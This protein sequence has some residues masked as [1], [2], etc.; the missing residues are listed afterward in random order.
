LKHLDEISGDSERTNGRSISEVDVRLTEVSLA[1]IALILLA[2][3]RKL[4]LIPLLTAIATVAGTFLISPIYTSTASFLPPQ[5]QGVGGMLGAQLGALAGLAGASMGIKNPADQYV[6]LLQSR[7]VTDRMIVRFDLRKRYDTEYIEQTRKI[8]DRR[9]NVSAGPKDGLVYIEVEDEDKERAAEMANAFIEELKNVMKALA[10][11]EAAQRRLFFEEQMGASRKALEVAEA[12][13]QASG[14]GEALLRA[15]PRAAM[16]EVARL[17][18]AVT[19]AELKLSSLL[20]FLSEQNPDVI[21]AK[22]EVRDLRAKLEQ[23]S[24]PRTGGTADSNAYVSK[25][26]DFKYQEFLFEQLARQFEL[27]RIDEAREGGVIQV[28]DRAVAAER[29]T[30][31]KRL[32][33]GVIAGVLTLLALLVYIAMQRVF[34]SLARDPRMAT[35]VN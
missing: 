7:T 15:E 21:Q 13:L 26:R 34:Q 23:S 10:L 4:V 11:G 17:K 12:N 20:G 8:L 6:G 32:L 3:A 5:Q 25:Y 18:A 19:T 30:R 31:P 33:A 28:V 9:V 35:I 14:V 27:A 2:H 29:K 1:N 24:I 22:R 16:E